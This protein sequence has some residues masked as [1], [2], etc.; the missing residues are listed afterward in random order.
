[1]EFDIANRPQFGPVEIFGHH[2]ALFARLIR[3]LVRIM[4]SLLK[5]GIFRIEIV[6]RI[7]VD[8]SVRGGVVDREDEFRLEI[9]FAHTCG[10][11]HFIEIELLAELRELIEL[12][13]RQ[14]N[15]G[16]GTLLDQFTRS[17]PLNRETRKLSL[18]KV[19]LNDLPTLTDVCTTSSAFTLTLAGSLT[20]TT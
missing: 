18:H 3:I 10:F 15:V 11:Q 2:S 8:H 13:R 4:G 19:E 14:P 16:G 1:M 12:W 6:S 9:F 20:P 7:A 5:V 17:A